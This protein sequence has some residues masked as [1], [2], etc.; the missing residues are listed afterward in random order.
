MNTDLNAIARRAYFFSLN[1]KKG[2]ADII[3]SLSRDMSIEQHG[4]ILNMV[5]NF[6]QTSQGDF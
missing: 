6:Y 3:E 1:S 5:I 4:I 2:I